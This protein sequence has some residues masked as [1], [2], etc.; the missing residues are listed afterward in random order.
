MLPRSA[1]L[2]PGVLVLLAVLLGAPSARAG[3]LSTRFEISFDRLFG[4]P[5]ATFT[6]GPGLGSASGSGASATWTIPVGAAPTG[7]T[8]NITIPPIVPPLTQVRFVLEGNAE[9]GV[10][11]ASSPGLLGVNAEIDL[12][13]YE[14]ITLVAVPV[15]FGRPVSGTFGPSYGVVGSWQANAWTTKTTAV[16]LLT[17]YGNGATTTARMGSNTLVDGQGTI[18]LVSAIVVDTNVTR[19]LAIFGRLTVAFVP[20]PG[21]GVLGLAGAALLAALGARRRRAARRL[22]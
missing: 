11:S 7:T 2:V 12:R 6:A 21:A 22:R 14:G 13:S 17:L 18:S 16:T 10:F 15:T 3:I 9:G 4:L 19:P 20:E 1:R 5:G 8:T